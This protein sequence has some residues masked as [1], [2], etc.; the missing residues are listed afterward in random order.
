MGK[1]ASGVV[2]TGLTKM[3]MASRGMLACFKA[4][5][6]LGGKLSLTVGGLLGFAAAVKHRLAPA[7]THPTERPRN[8]RSTQRE[9]ILRIPEV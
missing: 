3:L 7:K 5:L 9:N 6:T 1:G 2:C 4:A 8:D